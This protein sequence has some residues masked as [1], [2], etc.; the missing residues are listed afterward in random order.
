MKTSIKPSLQKSKTY[1]TY[2]YNKSLLDMLDSVTEHIDTENISK[3]NQ[4]N[5]KCK[6][7]EKIIMNNKLEGH[8]TSCFQNKI[9]L[10]NSQI[11]NLKIQMNSIRENIKHEM[12]VKGI[13][14]LISRNNE[15]WN[16]IYK[17][18]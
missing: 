11:E 6:C 14:I 15:K 17:Q 13:E 16:K 9:T 1:I 10:M 4:N 2:E 5:N 12:H 18:K 7:C 3:N 8:Q